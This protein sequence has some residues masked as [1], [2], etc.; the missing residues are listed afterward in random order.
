MLPPGSPFGRP[1]RCNVK[2]PPPSVTTALNVTVSDVTLDRWAAPPLAATDCTTTASGTPVLMTVAT[3][4]LP[5]SPV[6]SVNVML[7]QR[8]AVRATGPTLA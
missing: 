7:T 4:T 3:A 6:S 8:G 1:T 2:A 5:T